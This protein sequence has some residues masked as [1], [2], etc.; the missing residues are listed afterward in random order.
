MCRFGMKSPVSGKLVRRA[1]IFICTRRMY[2]VLNKVCLCDKPTQDHIQIEGRLTRLSME[3]LDKICEVM[4][5][6]GPAGLG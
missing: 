1:V 5:S 2:A 3:Y 4:A 6:R